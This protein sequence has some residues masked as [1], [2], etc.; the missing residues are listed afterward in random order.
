MDDTS[1]VRG[2]LSMSAAVLANL[3]VATGK[4]NEVHQN[5]SF[6]RVLVPARSKKRHQYRRCGTIPAI[7]NGEARRVGERAECQ[8]TAGN[9]L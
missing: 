7:E 9:S 3:N 1:V 8:S 4:Q 2:Y 5:L 6:D